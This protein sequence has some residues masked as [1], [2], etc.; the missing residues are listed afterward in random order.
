MSLDEKICKTSR[1]QGS[2]EKLS[3]IFT[4]FGRIN[5]ITD[6]RFKFPNMANLN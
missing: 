5:E 2:A 3:I 1:I 4:I 6:A